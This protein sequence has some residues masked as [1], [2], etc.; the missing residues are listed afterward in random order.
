MIRTLVL[1]QRVMA[2]L[3]FLTLLRRA[4]RESA[5]MPIP[6]NEWIVTP[7]TLQAAI[8]GWVRQTCHPLEYKLITCR[9]SDCDG[10]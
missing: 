3:F 2:F 8:P 5:P 9:R 4:S 6:A 10:V 1:S 7:P